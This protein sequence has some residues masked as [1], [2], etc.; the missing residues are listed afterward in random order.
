MH[1]PTATVR[2]K[3]G[4]WTLAHASGL[5]ALFG[6]AL[7]LMP[8][9]SP[10]Q[11]LAYFLAPD[12]MEPPQCL[13]TLKGKDAKVLIIA[14]H[15]GPLPSD[16][17]LMRSDWDLSARLT[18]LLEERYKANNDRVKIVPPTQVKTYMNAQPR[19]RELPPQDVGKHFDADWVINLEIGSIS[20]YERSS[21]NFFYHG[22]AEIQV[23][24]TDVHKPVGE[25]TVFDETYQLEY[26]KSH[27]LEKTE[28]S[29][30]KFRE[31]FIDRIARDLAQYFAAHEPRDK[32]NP[33]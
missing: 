30:Q 2:I 10:L 32:Y 21:A 11:V 3:G 26:P 24:V 23:T 18:R 31:K 12:S 9:C 27:P 29:P 33:D 28:M 4:R 25:G 7:L 8:G 16:P 22:T 1:E 13:L 15:A 5:V 6:A 19:W 14:A 17:A 20:L